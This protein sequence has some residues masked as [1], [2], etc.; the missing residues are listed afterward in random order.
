M[1]LE[2]VASSL[3]R[4]LSYMKV[5]SVHPFLA[6]WGPNIGCVQSMSESSG[7]SRSRS[8]LG[9]SLTERTSTKSVGRFREVSG[10]D[11]TTSDSDNIDVH[12]TITSMSAARNALTSLCNVWNMDHGMSKNLPLDITSQDRLV[13]YLYTFFLLYYWSIVCDGSSI[14]VFMHGMVWFGLIYLKKWIP[15]WRQSWE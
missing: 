9:C 13:L 2:Q 15:I 5:W 7:N 11:P 1:K 10:I 12:N 8:S 14:Y 6:V 4:T 3:I